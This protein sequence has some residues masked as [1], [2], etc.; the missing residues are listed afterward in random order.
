LDKYF[1]DYPEE[2]LVHRDIPQIS[3]T[4]FFDDESPFVVDFGCG[5]GRFTVAQAAQHSDTNFVG[6]DVSSKSLWDAVHQAT[7]LKLENIHFIRADLRWLMEY[8]ADDSIATAYIMFP[9][10]HKPK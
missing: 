8:M 5:R 10:P 3:P 9:K 6:I 1:T 7:R 2:T 4:T